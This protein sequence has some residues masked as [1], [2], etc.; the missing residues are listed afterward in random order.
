LILSISFSLISCDFNNDEE[1]KR[2]NI[3]SLK[4]VYAQLLK[5]VWNKD[6]ALNKEIKFISY[7]LVDAPGNLNEDDIHEIGDDFSEY[8]NVEAKYYDYYELKE[9]GYAED[10]GIKNGVLI[11][12]DNAQNKYESI[13]NSVRL[14]ITKYRGN[15]GAYYLFA[16]CEKDESGKW[17]Y[18]ITQE[19]V[20]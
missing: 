2:I 10:Y 8:R 14:K 16:L 6:T 18:E 4:E 12:I 5:D 20:S 13:E 15:L 9:K 7:D 11:S 17:E 1:R 3:E 19:A